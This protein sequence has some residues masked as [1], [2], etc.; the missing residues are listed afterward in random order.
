MRQRV[1]DNRFGLMPSQYFRRCVTEVQPFCNTRTVI[2]HRKNSIAMNR[3]K[4]IRLK[5]LYLRFRIA[6]LWILLVLFVLLM[7]L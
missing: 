7:S 4:A 2:L 1:S 3:Y 6:M 5:R